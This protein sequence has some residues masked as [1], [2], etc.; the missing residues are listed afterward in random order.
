MIFTCQNKRNSPTQNTTQILLP[1]PVKIRGNKMIKT[2]D[3]T[4]RSMSICY[5]T[6]NEI[7]EALLK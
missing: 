1:V 5:K 4:L 6:T 7:Q 2:Q 3:G